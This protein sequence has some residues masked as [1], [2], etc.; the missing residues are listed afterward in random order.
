[1]QTIY[2]VQ[3]KPKKNISGWKV[4][5]DFNEN[6]REIACVYFDKY[7]AEVERDEW[8]KS[9]PSFEYRVEPMHID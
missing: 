7:V 2:V 9:D 1:M 3:G 6:G 5:K 8:I 4:C